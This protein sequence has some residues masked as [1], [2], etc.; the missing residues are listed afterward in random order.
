[1]AKKVFERGSWD[2]PS[3]PYLDASKLALAAISF[4]RAYGNSENFSYLGRKE[5]LL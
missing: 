3:T 4:D 1:L 2:S 5:E